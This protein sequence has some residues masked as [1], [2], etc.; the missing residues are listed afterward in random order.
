[1]IA[2]LNMLATFALGHL[3]R[4]KGQAAPEYVMIIGFIS[5]V[6]VLAF[7]LLGSNITAAASE[8]VRVVG[9]WNDSGC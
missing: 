4:D 7:V 2:R 8:V 3:R 1:M 9:C 5:L 6:I